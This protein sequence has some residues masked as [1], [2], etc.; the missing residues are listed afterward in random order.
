MD[1]SVDL[2]NQDAPAHALSDDV[3][4][5]LA[6]ESARQMAFERELWKYRHLHVVCFGHA[7]NFQIT[8]EGEILKKRLEISVLVKEFNQQVKDMSRL[9]GTLDLWS[10]RSDAHRNAHEQFN[11]SILANHH[12]QLN[13]QHLHVGSYVAPTYRVPYLSVLGSSD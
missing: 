4:D 2:N 1:G 5:W 12:L 3:V 6:G 11:M 10:L 13:E 8:V 9:E 7:S